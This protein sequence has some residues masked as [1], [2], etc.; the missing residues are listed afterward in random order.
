LFVD[1][2]SER[3]E[4]LRWRMTVARFEIQARAV[5]LTA[6][7]AV[8]AI[9]AAMIVAADWTLRFSRV[10]AWPAVA[11]IALVVFRLPFAGLLQGQALRRVAIGPASAELQQREEPFTPEAIIPGEEQA[12]HERV[13]Y[14]LGTLAQIYQVQID[15]LR[16][17]RQAENGLM[18]EA[19]RGWF[20][21]IAKA[22]DADA[23]SIDPLMAWLIERG[24]IVLR[25]DDHYVLTELGQVF[26]NGIDGFWYAPKAI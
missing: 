6:L 14:I 2:I 10:L 18:S 21:A 19:A 1:W 25:E 17:L 8:G 11:L 22:P 9:I 16:H 23:A 3:W 7:A 12:Q 15:F 24:L 20:R 5:G 13:V 26:L 4:A